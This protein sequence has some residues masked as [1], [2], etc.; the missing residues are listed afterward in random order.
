MSN[1]YL[2]VTIEKKWRTQIFNFVSLKG[3]SPGL[4]LGEA[5]THADIIKILN[6]LLQLTSQWSVSQTIGGFFII[7]IVKEIMIF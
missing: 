7:F 1:I 3:S 4:F 5:P 2:K 6:F